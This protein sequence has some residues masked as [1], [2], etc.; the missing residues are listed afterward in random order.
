MSVAACTHQWFHIPEKQTSDGEGLSRCKICGV[1]S[2]ILVSFG[3]PLPSADA[4]AILSHCLYLRESANLKNLKQAITSLPASSTIQEELSVTYD[5]IDYI[6]ANGMLAHAEEDV[7]DFIGTYS[8]VHGKSGN[9]RLWFNFEPAEFDALL[10]SSNLPPSASQGL[11]RWDDV[12][13]L[14]KHD[15]YTGIS[16]AVDDDGEEVEVYEGFL[17]SLLNRIAQVPGFW[18]WFST[19]PPP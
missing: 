11:L 14:A 3:E 15:P 19:T 9:V 8:D 1:Y 12:L 13:I 2:T 16:I 7:V 6:Q 18:Y 17:H 4:S 10:T 5:W